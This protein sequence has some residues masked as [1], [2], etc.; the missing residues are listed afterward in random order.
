[1]YHFYITL[2]TAIPHP[3][4]NILLAAVI[5]LRQTFPTDLANDQLPNKNK[6]KHKRTKSIK[7]N[8]DDNNNTDRNN[9]KWQQELENI[10]KSN[11]K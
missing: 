9:D 10:V 3:G 5:I 6:N 8:K 4:Q 11:S 2:P 1:M 7:K